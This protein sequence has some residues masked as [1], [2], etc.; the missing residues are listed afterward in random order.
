LRGLVFLAR[1]RFLEA[2]SGR[3]N[4]RRFTD[5]FEE[6]RP[7]VP[8]GL[9]ALIERMMAKDPAQRPQTPQE[10]ADTL[11]PYTAA[12]IGAPPDDEM[13]RLSSGDQ[14]PPLPLSS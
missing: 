8:D 3:S 9:A 14:A 13:P 11:A 6:L 10:V 7:E 4:L 1:I 12:P 2:L 5:A